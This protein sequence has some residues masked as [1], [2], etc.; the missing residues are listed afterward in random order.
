VERLALIARLRPGTEEQAAE[1]V[2][3]GPPFDP[4]ERGLARHTVYL[5]A[6]EVVFV[7]EGDEVEWIVEEMV[8]EPAGGATG[9]VPLRACPGGTGGA[10]YETVAP[11]AREANA[12]SDSR[13]E[14]V[15]ASTAVGS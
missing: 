9:W 12:R 14:L 10:R 15:E 3:G 4:G 7:F 11:Q 2:A 8:Q 6:G 13:S 1:L 5:S